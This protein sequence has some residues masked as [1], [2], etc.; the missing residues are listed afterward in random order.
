MGGVVVSFSG[1]DSLAKTDLAADD[2]RS[3]ADKAT[4][5][6]GWISEVAD[7]MGVADYVSAAIGTAEEA[8]ELTQ[9]IETLVRTKREA[10]YLSSIGLES[11]ASAMNYNI[12]Q[13]LAG[14]AQST[15]AA[16]TPDEGLSSDQINDLVQR[17]QATDPADQE[18]LDE[19]TALLQVELGQESGDFDE[20]SLVSQLVRGGAKLA[21]AQDYVAAGDDMDER[22]RSLI[23]ADDERAL[24]LAILPTLDLQN[25]QDL[26]FATH[27][28]PYLYP[29]ATVGMGPATGLQDP[30]EGEGPPTMEELEQ[31]ARWVNAAF[32]RGAALE[33]QLFG[34][35]VC[36]DGY[37][38]LDLLQTG[39]SAHGSVLLGDLATTINEGLAEG[40]DLD[41]AIEAMMQ[42][43]SRDDELG[44]I[45]FDTEKLA[46]LGLSESTAVFL[47]GT[48][49]QEQ[50]ARYEGMPNRPSIS[51]IL[52]AAYPSLELDPADAERAEQAA[53]E[54]LA[55]FD[56]LLDLNLAVN[57]NPD[58]ITLNDID[59]LVTVI[60]GPQ[61]EQDELELQQKAFL[62]TGDW[63]SADLFRER[64]LAEI[65]QIAAANDL[66]VDELGEM[67]HSYQRHGS[68]IF[69]LVGASKGSTDLL[70]LE[71]AD[72]FLALDDSVSI[73]R[74]AVNAFALTMQARPYISLSQIDEIDEQHGGGTDGTLSFGDLKEWLQGSGLPIAVQDVMLG[75]ANFG[76]IDKG[77]SERFLGVL[78]TV[79]T[80]IAVLGL[81]A[82]GAALTI[83]F[84][85][86]G[87]AVLTVAG[88]G[89]SLATIGVYLYQG[90]L[91]EAALEGAFS[92][93]D[94]IDGPTE[95]SELGRSLRDRQ[96]RHLMLAMPDDMQAVAHLMDPSF[97]RRYARGEIDN[98]ELAGFLQDLKGSTLELT[99][100]QLKL[101]RLMTTDIS[102]SDGR[103]VRLSQSGI[104][105]LLD[106][107][108]AYMDDLAVRWNELEPDEAWDLYNLTVENPTITYGAFLDKWE[109]GLRF[110]PSVRQMKRV[111]PGHRSGGRLVRAL[112]RDGLPKPGDDFEAHHIVAA[113]DPRA[114][115][116]RALLDKYGVDLDESANGAWLPR[117]EGAAV[118]AKAPDWTPHNT[119]HTDE[120]Y[121]RVQSRLQE[122]LAEAK[123]SYGQ[124]AT[125]EIGD[126]LRQELNDIAED[127]RNG[128]D[129]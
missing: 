18:T 71:T 17:I 78:E 100:D 113:N 13:L 103:R 46:V 96:L 15:L 123:Q 77:G 124:N 94:L 52:K 89:V 53:V 60:D 90:E 55:N 76:G 2:L 91:G 69:K 56:I 99:E 84:P 36:D 121:N 54:F 43:A 68:T 35:G 14:I 64:K 59:L 23:F 111:E 110:D 3:A 19:L 117:N 79:G 106:G 104:D 116:S 41:A 22:R 9:T 86:A 127:L 115:T 72:D 61:S 93:L 30:W 39:I 62:V 98:V 24:A 26:W 129:I 32:Q 47:Y 80:A 20:A 119:L 114:N 44:G 82:A 70:K 29:N 45:E 66:T 112:E 28:L 85:P 51:E 102:L 11:T 95:L 38:L 5:V 126:A 48:L 21:D 37:A 118:T 27:L 40:G 42:Y 83:G 10:L 8:I 63:M 4:E 81:V 125:Q 108:G 25:K 97:L 122:A 57:G 74:D 6:V 107:K 12:E 49:L 128:V 34:E 101:I 1:T 16:V 88:A 73:D 120:Y 33:G 105:A 109:S 75:A 65:E 50:V 92:V 67:L 58:S 31:L 87:A 7:R